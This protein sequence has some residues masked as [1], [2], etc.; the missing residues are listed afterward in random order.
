MGILRE[1]EVGRSV[2][3]GGPLEQLMQLIEFTRLE[4]SVDAVVGRFAERSDGVD[5]LTS[6]R[7]DRDV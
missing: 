3:V 6:G 4:L 7:G 5:Q 2:D 1:A